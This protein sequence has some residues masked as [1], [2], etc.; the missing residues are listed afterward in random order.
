MPNA[1]P[2]HSA[3][4]RAERHT[5]AAHSDAH[6]CQDER[7]LVPTAQDLKQRLF[8]QLDLIASAVEHGWQLNRHGASALIARRTPCP[9][10]HSQQ[11]SNFNHR[12]IW[13]A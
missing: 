9:F 8:R 7:F 11:N 3:S 10:R 13:Y 12:Q 2:T 5:G 6:C 4:Q 1:T